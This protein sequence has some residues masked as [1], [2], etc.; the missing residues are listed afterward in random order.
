M[1]LETER[2]QVN[3]LAESIIKI[4]GERKRQVNLYPVTAGDGWMDQAIGE[5]MAIV[6]NIELRQKNE[7][8]K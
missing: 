7:V 8:T 2:D 4:W 3:A 1:S 6:G 5:A